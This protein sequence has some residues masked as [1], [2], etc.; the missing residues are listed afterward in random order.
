MLCGGGKQKGTRILAGSCDGDATAASVFAK[1][2]RLAQAER[3]QLVFAGLSASVEKRFTVLGMLQGLR[4]DDPDVAEKWAEDTLLLRA[5]TLVARWLVDPN[6]RLVYN[7]AMLHDALA[8]TSH[9]SDGA[10]GP[11]QLL[12][13]GSKRLVPRGAIAA[14]GADDH[15]YLLYRGEVHVIEG[16]QRTATV[17]PGAFFNERVVV[18]GGEGAA[19]GQAGIT[20]YAAM[21]VEDSVMLVISRRQRELMRLHDP[22][23]AYE[24]L[25]GVVKQM[26]KTRQPA[27]RG[28]SQGRLDINPAGTGRNSKTRANGRRG[29]GEVAE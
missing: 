20:N 11:A 25:T 19:Y 29:H 16:G 27:R 9:V 14:A 21:A 1:L 28:T 8:S 4:F 23:A 5:H 12:K 7:K 26:D 2:A 13:W 3:I 15:L 22:H 17:Y 6:T 24:L 18:G 10:L